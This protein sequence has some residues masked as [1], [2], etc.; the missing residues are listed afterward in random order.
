MY[1]AN[2]VA[3]HGDL[4]EGG[5]G[6]TLKPSSFVKEASDSEVEQLIANGRAGMPPYG[7]RLSGKEVLDLVALMRS[8]QE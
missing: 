2:C 1:A 8:W 7:E 3:C 5:I 6:S 4:G